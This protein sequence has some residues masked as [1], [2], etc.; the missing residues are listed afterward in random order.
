[1]CTGQINTH[2]TKNSSQVENGES[3]TTPKADTQHA[4]PGRLSRKERLNQPNR[5]RKEE[6]RQHTRKEPPGQQQ[7]ASANR[8]ER[9]IRSETT[10]NQGERPQLKQNLSSDSVVSS[11]H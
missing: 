3:T 7:E 2:S 5:N 6:K 8:E 11:T 10:T 9:K 1:M 4:E